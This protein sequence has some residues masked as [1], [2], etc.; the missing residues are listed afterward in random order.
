MNFSKRSRYGLRAL[1]DLAMY[2]KDG[3]IQLNEIAKRNQ[4]P[5]KYL[6][7]IF[8]SLRKAGIL[9]SVKGKLG[10]YQ[11][12]ADPEQITAADIIVVLDGNYFLED[13]ERKVDEPYMASSAAIEECII[14]PVNEQTQAL[15]KKIT[16]Q[17]LVDATD[18]IYNSQ[19]DMYYI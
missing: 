5:E 8:A 15:L 7:Q 18:K 11:L 14:K 13:E 10:G 4:I 2:G 6:E 9:K 19:G 17:I 3:C 1:I 16:L 12:A